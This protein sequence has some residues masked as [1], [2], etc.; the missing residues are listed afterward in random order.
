MNFQDRSISEIE[1]SFDEHFVAIDDKSSNSSDE[2]SMVEENPSR[3]ASNCSTIINSA[4]TPT[5]HPDPANI[6]DIGADGETPVN[7][8]AGIHK[9]QFDPPHGKLA[10]Q[11]CYL[12]NLST[13][14]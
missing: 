6:P 12:I 11:Y 7:A 2:L 5:R 14:M 4:R 13:A 9:H 8:A 10:I 1:T 3:P